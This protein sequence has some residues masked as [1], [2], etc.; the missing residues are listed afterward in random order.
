M[1]AL[2]HCTE[3]A[4]SFTNTV[5]M[6]KLAYIHLGSD[7]IIYAYFGNHFVF[8]NSSISSR[9]EITLVQKLENKP[10][11]IVTK[12]NLKNL[13]VLLGW[14]KPQAPPSKTQLPRSL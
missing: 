11:K 4:F 5:S 6:M 10:N 3:A 2:L 13:I 9:N 7:L 12:C 14:T 8:K 1:L